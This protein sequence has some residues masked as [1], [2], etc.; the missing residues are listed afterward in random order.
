MRLVDKRSPKHK[1]PSQKN[2]DSFLAKTKLSTISV[3]KKQES[4]ATLAH[5]L[6]RDS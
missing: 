4:A 6:S 1:K 2:N 3:S 5:E